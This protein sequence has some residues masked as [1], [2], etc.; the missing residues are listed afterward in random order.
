MNNKRI[1]TFEE[2][3]KILPFG[4][5]KLRTLCQNKILPVT[6]VG[7]QYIALEENIIQ[8]VNDNVGR[9]IAC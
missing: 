8:W 2:M 5:T 4:R 7:G 6:K 1:V 9:E 3:L